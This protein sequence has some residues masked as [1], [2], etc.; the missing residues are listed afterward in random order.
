MSTEPAYTV[1]TD[2]LRRTGKGSVRYDLAVIERLDRI[3]VLLE[4]LAAEAEASS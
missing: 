3:V 2:E 4:A 1:S